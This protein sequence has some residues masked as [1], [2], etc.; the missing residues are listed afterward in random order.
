MNQMKTNLIHSIPA[1]AACLLLAACA[2]DYQGNFKMEKPESVIL[3]EEIASYSVLPEYASNAG[4]TLGVAV[5]PD[6]LASRGLVY[7]IVKTNF[8][9]VESASAITP[10]AFKTEDNSYD[11][12]T[13]STLVETAEKEGFKVFGPA[14]CS[15]V[16][17]PATYLKSVIADE[18]IPYQPWFEEILITDFENDAIGKAYAS[19][20]KSV[21]SVDVKVMEDPMGQQGK[22]LGGTKLTMDVPLVEITLPE[23]A[24]LADVSR[25]KLK[26][27]LLDGTPTSARIQIE[28]SGLNDKANPYTSKGQW[29]EYIFELSKI[30]FK[31][32]ELKQN[33]FKLAVGAYGSSV[34]CCIDDIMIRLE[35]PTGD[36]T[37][38]VKTPEEKTQIIN[39]ELY[40]W[41]DGITDVCAGTVKDYIIFD[42]PLESVNARFFWNEYLG[43]GYVADVQKAVIAKVGNDARFH[44]SQTLTIG[45]MM[46]T[47][48]DALKAEVGK[49]EKNGVKVDGINAVL[50]ATYSFDAATQ[51]SIDSQTIECIKSLASFGKPVR[52]SSLKVN[53]LDESG[54]Q[55]NPV[56]LTIEQRRAIGEYYNLI[57]RT[58]LAELGS[59]AK[60]ISFSS[61]LDSTTD[62]A[63]WMQNGNRSFVYEGIV[64]GLTK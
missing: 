52:I 55:L 61:V 24:T 49:I 21:G 36:D 54:A 40:K 22:V 29:E 27:L 56:N 60:G 6:E 34:S 14:L 1:A 59:N 30:K 45:D 39:G 25:V 9:E 19:Q 15:N 23:G 62:V 57:I 48:V 18:V 64:K 26:C 8:N 28:S 2:E 50:N 11:F 10:L 13:L 5:D 4:I 7:S 46:A 37:V 41:V 31:E 16:N 3:D 43:D 63:P 38:I 35:H 47:N 17:I 58:F 33:K 32:A 20:K 44:V 12:A 53:A 42:Q 51:T